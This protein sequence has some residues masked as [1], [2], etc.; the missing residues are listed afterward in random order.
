MAE[1][2]LSRDWYQWEGEDGK[3]V[4]E[5]EYGTNTV[6]T[7]MSIEKWDLLKLFQEW[8]REIKENDE[9]HEFKYDIL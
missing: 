5:G 7:C 4:W 2:V 1:Q 8:G 3:R 9:G 6:Y